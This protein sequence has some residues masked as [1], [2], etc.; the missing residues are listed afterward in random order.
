MGPGASPDQVSQTGSAEHI[1]SSSSR[2]PRGTGG[3]SKEK[4]SSP[5]N[6]IWLCRHHGGVVDENLGDKYPP[7]L[8]RLFK[9]EHEARI[10]AEHEGLSPLRI[11]TLEILENPVFQSGSRIDFG[12][13]TVLVGNNATGK[14]TILRWLDQISPAARQWRENAARTTKP[15]RYRV[16]LRCPDEQAVGVVRE[17]TRLTFELNGRPVLINPYL[18]EFVFP[19]R[20]GYTGMFES[21][22]AQARR[23]SGDSDGGNLDDVELLARFM[24]ISSLL[25]PSLLPYVG[26]FVD[27]QMKDARIVE[28][29][30]LRK[31]FVDDLKRAPEHRATSLHR[32]SGSMAARLVL[33][34]QIAM[35]N[36]TAELVPTA[37]LLNLASL[38]LDPRNLRRYVDFLVSPAVAFQT[39]LE[40]VHESALKQ[41]LDWSLVVLSGRAPD[42]VVKQLS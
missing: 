40:T 15:I 3:L 10:A 41:D 31:V 38:H 39:V 32:I 5:E 22:L 9:R 33:D 11:Q 13:V 25:V 27:N 12:K 21:F 23:E 28:K 35:A 19:D 6:G 18:T 30:G 42:C 8:L 17:S 16:T 29:D 7:D 4:R 26:Q 34:L 37:L 36:L 20:H 2:G 14:T 1:Y 24:D